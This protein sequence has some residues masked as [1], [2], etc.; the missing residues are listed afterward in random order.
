MKVMIVD[1]KPRIRV[2]SLAGTLSASR[3]LVREALSC[4]N[5]SAPR[6]ATPVTAPISRLVLV[7]EAAIPERSGTTTLSTVG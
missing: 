7:A 4:E 6:I 3:W 2:F 1:L 5:T